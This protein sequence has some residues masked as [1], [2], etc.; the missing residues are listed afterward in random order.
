MVKISDGPSFSYDLT[1]YFWGTYA[2]YQLEVSYPGKSTIGFNLAAGV[3][4][5]L[6]E[7]MGIGFEIRDVIA[8]Y[9]LDQ[10]VTTSFERDASWW[11]SY[12]NF[13]PKVAAT[14]SGMLHNI[15]PSVYLFFGF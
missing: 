9:T 14:Q 6:G 11:T 1:Q 12:D 15:M 13:G 7:N 5:L 4:M 2:N 10:Q 8:K 3:K